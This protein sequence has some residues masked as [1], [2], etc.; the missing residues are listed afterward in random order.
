MQSVSVNLELNRFTEFKRRILEAEPDIDDETLADTLEG[1][2]NLHEALA[3][4]V[5]SAIDDADLVAA[6]KT[7][8][9]ESRERLDRL[10]GR[11][12]KK[13]ALA[14][15]AMEEAGLDKIMEPDFT[16]SLRTAPPSVVVTDESLIPEW[17]FVPQPPKLDKRAL[18]DT[19]KAGTF[20]NGAA[21]SNSRR[22]LSVRTK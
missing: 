12:E 8:I 6:L 1:A 19:L 10:S 3:A 4:L 17:F 7:R 11:M 5:R 14:L 21:L 18:L 20:V 15:V 13:R 9:A 16:L 2:T 22:S